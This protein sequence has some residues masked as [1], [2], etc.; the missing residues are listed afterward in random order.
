FK[1]GLF[2]GDLSTVA[3]LTGAVQDTPMLAELGRMVELVEHLRAGEA[4]AGLAMLRD[5]PFAP[6]YSV[7]VRYLTPSIAA[8][9]GDWEAA[10]RPVSLPAG[11]AASLIMHQQR[12]GLLESRRRYDE[13]DAEYRILMAAPGGTGLFAMDYAAFL[14]RRNRRDEALALYDAALTGR[15]PDSEAA[16]GRA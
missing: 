10:L 2:A 4:R 12:A 1:S 14:E 11:D 6:P 3:R 13:A 9:A 7:A 15:N 8:A 5:R 16:V